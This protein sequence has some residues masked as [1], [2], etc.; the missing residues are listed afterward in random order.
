MSRN[1]L[2]VED[3]VDIGAKLHRRRKPAFQAIEEDVQEKDSFA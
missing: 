3:E 1:A 2:F